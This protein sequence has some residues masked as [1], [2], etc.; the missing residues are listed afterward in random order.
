M[1]EELEGPEK[2]PGGPDPPAPP[3]GGT[4]PPKVGTATP[5]FFRQLSNF[6]IDVVLDFFV[7]VLD[8][9]EAMLPLAIN[10]APERA[11]ASNT[12][13]VERSPEDR[14]VELLV[15]VIATVWRA[16]LDDRLGESKPSMDAGRHGVRH[17]TRRGDPMVSHRQWLDSAKTAS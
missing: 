10:T 12:P 6:L 17:L 3:V 13:E 2:P 9:A 11:R 15:L 7:E 4:P 8:D 14:F 5:C 16:N 1:L